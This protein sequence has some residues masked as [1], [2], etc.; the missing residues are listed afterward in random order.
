MKARFFTFLGFVS[1]AL[2]VL[3][4]CTDAIFATIET[5]K[6]VATNTLPLLLSIFD[7]AVTA[8]NT[9]YVA[10]GAVFRGVLSGVGGTVTWTPNTT[11][12]SRPFNP[13]GNLICNAMALFGGAVWGGFI[14]PS[15]VASLYRSGPTPSFAAADGSTQIPMV[16]GEQVTLLRS[17]GPAPT[18]NLYI[19]GA[20]APGSGDYV[21]ELDY[22]PNAGTTYTATS[23]TGLNKP[24]VGVGFDGT[25][26][27]AA[28]G[29]NVDTG[30]RVYTSATRDFAS[31][32]VVGNTGIGADTING[33]FVADPTLHPGVVIITTKTSGVFYTTNSG[34]TWSHA[35]AD[36]PS[37]SSNPASYLAAAGPIDTLGD[38]YL[39]GSD[40][41]G[42]YT[43]SLSTGLT[44]F[45]DT[46]IL[47]YTSSVSKI[48]VD[49]SNVLMGTNFNGLWRAVFD[50]NGVVASGTNQ[51]WIHE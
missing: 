3:T 30:W 42:Y 9:Y 37:G 31:P 12:T 19:G 34:G 39:I 6:K 11:D 13:P 28:A 44:R 48:L 2:A 50:A 40:G 14:S 41:F 47:L 1:L 49:G 10:A 26:Y 36:V 25:L 18:P 29:S 7:I 16:P 43:L 45:Q 8:P 27:W 35:G 15:G 4:S 17:A 23:L 22:V 32:T 20:T 46:T 33:L 21:Y 51:Y 38:K 5:E 24:V